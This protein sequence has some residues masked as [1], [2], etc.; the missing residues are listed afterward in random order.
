MIPGSTTTKGIDLANATALFEENVLLG[1]DINILRAL[2]KNVYDSSFLAYQLTHS[3]KREIARYTQGITIVH[4]YG[5][6]VLY[7]VETIEAGVFNQQ[8]ERLA[9]LS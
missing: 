3:K 2:K 8:Q 7:L 5:G 4:L 9:G 1:G 6:Q